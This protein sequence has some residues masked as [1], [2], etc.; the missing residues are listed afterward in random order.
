MRYH[1][2]WVVASGVNCEINT[3]LAIIHTNV[4]TIVVALLWFTFCVIAVISL[5]K[6]TGRRQI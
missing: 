6:E 1:L 2:P 5:W 4:F 3:A